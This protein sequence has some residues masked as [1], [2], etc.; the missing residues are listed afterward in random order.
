MTG[1]VEPLRSPLGA[2]TLVKLG[3]YLYEL[4]FLSFNNKFLLEAHAIDLSVYGI[5]FTLVL[6]PD[7]RVLFE[8][9][10]FSCLFEVVFGAFIFF[11][12]LLFF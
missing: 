4:L 1:E 10:R 11:F 7:L 12:F 2:I 6:P 3:N 5:Y 8:I 9:V